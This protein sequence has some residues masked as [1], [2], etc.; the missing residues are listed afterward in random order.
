MRTGILSSSYALVPNGS[1]NP[2]IRKCVR[3]PQAHC[4]HPIHDHHSQAADQVVLP[5]PSLSSNFH[6][7]KP[8][9]SCRPTLHVLT[10][11]NKIS[12]YSS[13]LALN[14]N[15]SSLEHPAGY[16]IIFPEDQSIIQQV[17]VETCSAQKTTASPHGTTQG[18]SM[19]QFRAS[20]TFVSCNAKENSDTRSCSSRI[21][22]THQVDCFHNRDH[23]VDPQG[24]HISL[25][26]THN[27]LGVDPQACGKSSTHPILPAHRSLR[28]AHIASR[29]QF[30]RTQIWI[31]GQ[32]L[33]LPTGLTLSS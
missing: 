21:S 11:R 14:Q 25:A 22:I 8:F 27:V 31:E 1:V 12:E 5:V 9:P 7:S 6:D 2:H 24:L 26:V 16:S 17:I 10:P 33:S 30:S 15:K 28:R 32:Q 20:K 29:T 19:S 18:T 23:S 3:D 4:H 13:S